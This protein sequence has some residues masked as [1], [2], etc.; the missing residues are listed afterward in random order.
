[1][2]VSTLSLAF[3]ALVAALLV[4]MIFYA[5]RLNHRLAGLRAQE[6]ELRDG[7]AR[8]G[9]ATA[10]A[11][12]SAGRLKSAGAEAERGV[13]AAVDRAHAVRDELAFLI[14]RADRALR[15]SEPPGAA[16]SAPAANK[17]GRARAPEDRPA[18]GAGT[19]DGFDDAGRDP[20]PRE[21]AGPTRPRREH[22]A[23]A[24]SAAE[25]ELLRAIRAA[26]GD[27]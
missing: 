18:N 22:G 3:E 9:E 6:A 24:R 19:I 2:S 8:F 23:A 16:R 12:A 5:A 11:E 1:M 7:I 10:R 15:G 26:H 13:R 25:R 4:V 27:G 21:T 20:A 14:E 17:R